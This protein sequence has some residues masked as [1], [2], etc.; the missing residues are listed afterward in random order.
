MTRSKSIFFVGLLLLLSACNFPGALPT[1]TPEPTFTPIPSNTPTATRTATPVP[2]PT[3]TP[4]PAPTDTPAPTATETPI[5]IPTTPAP[6]TPSPYPTPAF[7]GDNLQQIELPQ[8]VINGVGRMWVS[9]IAVS[10]SRPTGTP[11]TLQP[12]SDTQSIY[13]SSPDA[14]TRLKVIDLPASTD[15]RVYWSPN[16]AYL[17]YLIVDGDAPGLYMLDI[18]SATTQRLFAMRDFTPR[19]FP[20][21][22]IWSNDS[23]RLILTLPTAYDFDIFSIRPDGSDLQNLTESGAY[24]LWP[25]VSPDGASLAFVSDRNTCPSWQPDATPTCYKPDANPPTGGSLYVMDIA[26]KQVRLLSEQFINTPPRWITS[27]RVAFSTGDPA[28]LTAGAALWW[29]DARG[30]T[31][32]RVSGTDSTVFASN[33]SWSPDGSRVI[34][35]ESDTSTRLVIR[36]EKGEIVGRN[37]ELNF[38]RFL[39]QAT[40]AA[41]GQRVILGGRNG[42]CPFGMLVAD[43]SLE[44]QTNVQSGPGVCEPAFA[45]DGRY[46]AYVGTS[47]GGGTS[48]DGRVDV[49]VAEAS[50]LGARLLTS[51]ITGQIK[52]LGWI[53][54]GQ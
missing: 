27:A 13:I 14:I 51:R 49:Y 42:Q 16:G 29:G 8:Q 10:D 25:A 23:T 36:D 39:F 4:T 21:Q 26:T 54:G 41:D 6:P 34:Y 37:I 18:R 45:P 19:G 53:R 12:Q 46:V 35:Q 31:V 48:R 28:D 52:L 11:G 7:V 43:A 5:P 30:G 24:E 38:P 50:G 22:P 47:R 33:E 40:W 2:T 17:A 20:I 1:P 32:Q 3:V 15:R 44:L 9:Y